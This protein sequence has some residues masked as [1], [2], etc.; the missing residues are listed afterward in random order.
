MSRSPS[1]GA[2]PSLARFFAARPNA[3]RAFSPSRPASLNT[4][5]RAA[6]SLTPMPIVR[7]AGPLLPIAETRSLTLIPVAAE[8]R[9]RESRVATWF[10]AS[11]PN[12]RNTLPRSRMLRSSPVIRF[13]SRIVLDTFVRSEPDSRN[14]CDT[15]PTAL[16]MSPMD[17]AVAGARSLTAVLSLSRSG[18]ILAVLT[19][20]ASVTS[21]HCCPRLYNSRPAAITPAARAAMPT[22]A[23]PAATTPALASAV[24]ALPARSPSLP[25]SIPSPEVL[26]DS[27]PWMDSRS[28]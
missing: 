15:A 18:P 10:L 26:P 23:A 3:A 27:R 25:N 1:A 21:S 24:P 4:A 5:I 19:D 16:P 20:R 12:P 14:A 28:L 2:L 17:D 7:R 6:P 8:A 22:V 11:T 13:R 9:Y